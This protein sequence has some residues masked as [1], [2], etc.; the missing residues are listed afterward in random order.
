MRSIL[1]RPFSVLAGLALLSLSAG[2]APGPEP[3]PEEAAPAA[4]AAPVRATGTVAADDGVPI[5]Y[6]SWGSGDAAV[7]FVHCWAC[8][9]DFW[10]HQVEPVA[11]A[12]Y[13]VV[14]LDLPG[15]GGS[16]AAREEWSLAG[17]AADVEAVVEELGLERV[18]LVGHSMGG[19]VSLE[20]AQRLPGTVVGI[21]CVDTLHDVEFEWP[22]GMVETMTARLEQDYRAG[23]ESFVP[24]LFKPDAD[25]AVVE[26]VI[27]QAV[28]TTEPH[29]TIALMRAFPA[30]DPPGALGAAGVPIRCIN[31]APGEQG[32]PTAVETNRKY[33]DFDAVLM[34]G[35]GHY[36]QLERPEEF[37]RELLAVLEELSAPEPDSPGA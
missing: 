2:C 35:V 12:G 15:H 16:G 14:A 7:V 20:T 10:R 11:A 19:P 36:P 37:N 6:E 29:A 17:L 9:R 22:E 28:E 5:A 26:W 18:V 13:R 8:N 24:G 32:M 21:A 33:A 3:A 31:A 1:R 27:D 23:M 25:P 4:E 30:W 34:E